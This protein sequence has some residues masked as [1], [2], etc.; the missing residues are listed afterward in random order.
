MRYLPALVALFLAIPS[1]AGAQGTVQ[2]F[3]GDRVRVT[4]PDCQLLGQTG[5]FISIEDDVLSARSGENE[6][7]CPMEAVTRLEVSLGERDWQRDALKGMRYG[8]L[9]GLAGGA[10][11]IAT[12][13]RDEGFPT[14]DAFLVTAG[15]GAVGF[16]VGRVVAATGDPEDWADVTL[17]LGRPSLFLTGE[18]RFHLGFSLSLGR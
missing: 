3:G 6:I 1:W 2:V 8:L 12:S 18:G 16:L 4:A 7:R 5:T 11:I 17:P 13:D 9:L 10:V 14:L 15:T